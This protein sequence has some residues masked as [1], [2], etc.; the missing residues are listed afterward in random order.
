MI[1]CIKSF[2]F[3]FG[4]INLLKGIGY[5]M[6]L[7]IFKLCEK[8]TWIIFI[9][10]GGIKNIF[11]LSQLLNNISKHC[12]DIVELLVITVVIFYIYQFYIYN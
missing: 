12:V 3:S 6:R 11:R 10:D 8:S 5:H 4:Q 2:P 7:I 9:Y 1:H